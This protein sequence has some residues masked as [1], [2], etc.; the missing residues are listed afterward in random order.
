MTA[1]PSTDRPPRRAWMPGAQAVFLVF[2]GG[3]VGVLV[4]TAVRAGLAPFT[5]TPLALALVN[6]LGAFALGFL[7]GKIPDG[8]D[9]RRNL[10]GT[11][12]LG[13]F[14]SF[15]AFAG[16][17]IPGFPRDL[18]AGD[19]SAVPGAPD[20]PDQVFSSVAVNFSDSVSH[21][22]AALDFPFVDFASN[23]FIAM[24]IAYFSLL[25]GLFAAGAGLKL[26]SAGLQLR[27]AGLHQAGS[28][29]WLARDSRKQN[30]GGSEQNR[31]GAEQNWDGSEQNR[32]GADGG[33]R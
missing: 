13:G 25:I 30:Q 24:L 22:S 15:S 27:T 18:L 31:G 8:A 16:T 21:T 1:T 6:I 11:G 26:A 7:V 28:G 2:C 19:P 12:F 17:L 3:A 29:T 32:G 5:S 23:P 33:D 20:A 14:T 4:S 10:L 9:Y